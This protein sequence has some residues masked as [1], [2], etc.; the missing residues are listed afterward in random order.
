MFGGTDLKG[1]DDQNK[2]ALPGGLFDDS[3]D[4]KEL[5][6]ELMKIQ[7]EAKDTL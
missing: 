3:D 5:K 6:K 1:E 7:T 4:E 2:S